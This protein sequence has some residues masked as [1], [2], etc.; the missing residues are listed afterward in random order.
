MRLFRGAAVPSSDTRP[1]SPAG[2]D[3]GPVVVLV[4]PR[5][6][7]GDALEWAAAEAAARASELRIVYAFRWPR[8]L[9]P[10]GNPTVDLHVREAAEAVVT[11][12]IDRARR[13]APSLRIATTVYPGRQVAALLSEA[14][15]GALVVLSHNT[16]SLE[17]TLARRLVRRT[18][19]SLAV[20]GLS[21]A[22]SVG[23]NR[24]RVVVGVDDN[25]G[26]S[27]AL[28]FAFRAAQR[29]GIGLTVVHATASIGRGEVDEVVRI[30]R[31]AY[32]EVDVRLE[33]ARGPVDGVVLAESVAAALT[34]LGPDRHGVLHRAVRGSASY[35]VLRLARGPV[36]VVG[37]SALHRGDGG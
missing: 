3:N 31:M 24:G 33:L 12:A 36:V 9:D 7:D 27:A 13:I 18:T 1:I 2:P 20:I 14:S 29:R 10:L 23:P 28:G 22:G 30:W 34:V 16:K 37:R 32:P 6:S 4:D 15:A 11:A 21:T 35:N 25:G 17:R 19:A 26:P 8:L 5:G